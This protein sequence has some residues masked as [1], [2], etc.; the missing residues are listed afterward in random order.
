MRCERYVQQLHYEH[1]FKA[2]VVFFYIIRCLIQTV[3]E[4]DIIVHVGKYSV[5]AP[6]VLVS[7]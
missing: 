4:E 6:G 5:T 7:C 2:V 1:D 3:K